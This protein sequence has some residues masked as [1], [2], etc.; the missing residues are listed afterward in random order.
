G[1]CPLGLL[2]QRH[3]VARTLPGGASGPE[4]DGGV[5]GVAVGI[6]SAFAVSSLGYWQNIISWPAVGA[7]FTFSV[8]VGIIFGIYP[9][10]R[11]AQL[12]PIE[13]LRSE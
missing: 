11:A 1:V 9:A 6:G 3:R 13:A 7:A 2:A 10:M 12:E 8:A 5:V 4:C